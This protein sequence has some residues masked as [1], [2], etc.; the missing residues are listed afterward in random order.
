ME[1]SENSIVSIVPVVHERLH[2]SLIFIHSVTP[3]DCLFPF[4]FDDKQKIHLMLRATSSCTLRKIPKNEFEKLLEN[5]RLAD[6][7][8]NQIS[9]WL[10]YFSF[11]AIKIAELPLQGEKLWQE[12]DLAHLKILE[13]FS[14]NQVLEQQKKKE[15]AFLSREMDRR[16][17]QSSLNQLKS[18][19]AE[20]EYIFRGE[21]PD[22]LFK[23]CRLVGDYLRLSFKP[24]RKDTAQMNLDELLHRICFDSSIYYREVKLAEGWWQS[25]WGPFVGFY[26][27]NNKPVALLPTKE[28]RYRMIDL[29]AQY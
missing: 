22:L 9:D 25:D 6:A 4:P 27:P 16:N 26:G 19:L 23:V 18:V 2:G 10:A 17:L 5:K 20:E 1:V 14:K 12:L 29:E 24:P 21:G 11:A 8:K 3:G 15:S 13:D 28:N 7:F